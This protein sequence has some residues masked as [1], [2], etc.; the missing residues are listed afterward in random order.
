LDAD[1]D[2]TITIV[3]FRDV[4]KPAFEKYSANISEEAAQSSIF[5][6]LNFFI[7]K[8]NKYIIIKKMFKNQVSSKKVN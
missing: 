4:F 3:E 8:I 2:D 5:Y 7:F 6:I 1:N